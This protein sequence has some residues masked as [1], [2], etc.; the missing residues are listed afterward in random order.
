MPDIH[1]PMTGQRKPTGFSASSQGTPPYVICTIAKSPCSAPASMCW[2]ALPGATD[3]THG[4][5]YTRRKARESLTKERRNTLSEGNRVEEDHTG[6]HIPA[7]GS[8]LGHCM[9]CYLLLIE[10]VQP[11]KSILV[12]HTAHAMGAAANI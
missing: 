9:G 6:S 4:T 8:C 11:A 2:P 3:Q 7:E 12:V 10:Q 5:P 1:T